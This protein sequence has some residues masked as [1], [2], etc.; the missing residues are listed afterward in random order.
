MNIYKATAFCLVLGFTALVLIFAKQLLIPLVLATLMWLLVDALRNRLMHVTIL[1]QKLPGFAI[2][3]ISIITITAVLMAFY[4]IF[5]SQAT[6]IVDSL[7]TYEEK[8]QQRIASVSEYTGV[9][10]EHWV[11]SAA[12]S[13]DVSSM[14]SSVANSTGSLI[15]SSILIIIYVSFMLLEQSSGAKKL[16]KLAAVSPV[17]SVTRQILSDSS[18]QI[19]RYIWLKSVV[20]ALT[21]FLSYLMLLYFGVDFP[22]LWAILAFM[23]NFIPNIGSFLGVIFPSL[24]ALVQFDDFWSFALVVLSLGLI[25]FVVGNVFEPAYMGKSLNLSPLAILLSLS[26]WGMIWGIPGMFLAVPMMVA[27]SIVLS[28]VPEMR[29]I[30]ILMSEDGELA[31]AETKPTHNE[32]L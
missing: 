12:S 8:M 30:S 19:K 23:L 22:E 13:M 9:D 28:H 2:P 14:L 10:V 27:T 11:N 5:E 26:F 20:S 24:L 6:L 25:Q 32:S 1:G 15:A 16:A 7:P 18:F 17:F 3:I 4:A 21:G 31:Q 29:W